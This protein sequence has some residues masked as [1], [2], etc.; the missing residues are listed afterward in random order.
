MLLHTTYSHQRY[1]FCHR[2]AV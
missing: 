2:W 1:R